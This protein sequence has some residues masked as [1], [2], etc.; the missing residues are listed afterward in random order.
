MSVEDLKKISVARCARVSYLTHDGVRNVQEDINLYE[1]LINAIPPHDSP[2]E[3]VAT[4]C[5]KGSGNFKGW[6]QFRHEILRNVT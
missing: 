3:H 1:K 2:L 5:S 4:P 6:K